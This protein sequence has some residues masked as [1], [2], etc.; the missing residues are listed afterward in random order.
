VTRLPDGLRPDAVVVLGAQVLR[1]GRPSPSL[2][3]RL[4]HGVAVWR[5]F[6]EARLV[7][8][9]G[10]GDAPI[11]EA[12]AMRRMAEARGVPPE[13][14]VVED[15]SRST[16]DQAAEAARLARVWGWSHLVVVTDRYHSPRAL[17]L[18]RRLGLFVTGDP[19]RGRGV[20]SRPRRLAA[21]L[22]EIPAWGK[23]VVLVALGRHRGRGR[24]R[25]G[26]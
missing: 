2:R 15:R 25:A 17:F 23:A 20:G 22:R 11:S 10:I 4:E 13:R 18:F 7:V 24:A 9:G 12:E 21:V 16:M 5:R 3:C 1:S 6:P 19:V 26:T 8:A 14:I